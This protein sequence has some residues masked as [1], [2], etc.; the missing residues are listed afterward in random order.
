MT[1]KKILP[2]LYFAGAIFI[3]YGAIKRF[4]ADL[5]EYRMIFGFTTEDK[6]VYISVRLFVALLILLFGVKAFK[7]NKEES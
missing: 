4:S 3:A 6:Y 2:Y 7:K 1:L 5:D